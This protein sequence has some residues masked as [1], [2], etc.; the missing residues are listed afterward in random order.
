MCLLV[1]LYFWN[2]NFCPVLRVIGLKVINSPS[3]WF[4]HVC[5][6]LVDVTTAFHLLSC[7]PDVGIR[8]VTEERKMN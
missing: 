7:V 8:D 3:V 6:Q 2:R 4:D 1:R 5:R